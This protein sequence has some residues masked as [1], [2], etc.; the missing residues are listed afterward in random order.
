MYLWDVK[1][2]KKKL[3]T[4]ALTEAQTFTYFLA[5]LTL[6]TVLFQLVS[7]FPGTESTDVW[8]YVE[9]AGAVIFT[10][11]GTLVVYRANGGAAGRQFLV[12]YF[13][14]MW[15]LTIR[16]LVFLIPILI[17]TILLMFGLSETLFDMESEDADWVPMARTMVVTSWIWFLVFYYRL[18]VHMHDVAKAA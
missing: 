13:P 5:V 2:L 12:R 14:L 4:Q 16:F 8:D 1:T 15:V 7:L 9:Y 6:E 18:A 17:V 3:S 11:G 10:V